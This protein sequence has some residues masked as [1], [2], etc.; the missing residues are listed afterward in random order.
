MRH[1]RYIRY[2]PLRLAVFLLLLLTWFTQSMA[3]SETAVDVAG[4]ADNRINV[5]LRADGP[6]TP[7]GTATMTLEATPLVDAPD[8]SVR[9]QTPPGATLIG[10]AEESFGAVSAGRTVTSQRQVRFDS[11]GVYKMVVSAGFNLFA[12]MRFGA[13]GVLFFTVDPIAPRVSDK[14]PNAVSPMRSIIPAEVTSTAAT[15][16]TPSMARSADGDPCFYVSGTVVRI[17]RPTLPTGYGPDVI[18]PVTNALVEVNEEDIIFD[19]TYAE[20]YTDENGFFSTSFCDDDGVFD[21]ELEIYVTLWSEIYLDGELVAEVEDSSYIDENYEFETSPKASEGGSLTFNLSL[22]RTQSAIFNIADA[23]LDAYIVWRDNGGEA[24]GDSIFEEEGEVHWEPG[25]GDTGSHYISELGEITIADDPSDPDEWDDSVIIHEWGHMADDLYSCDDSPGGDHFVNQLV[26]DP[27][28][29]WGEGYPDYWQSA[30]RAARGRATPS[31]YLDLDGSESQ[32]ISINLENYHVAQPG[33][34]SVRNELAI[35]AALWDLQDTA[36][37]GQDTVAHGQ[38]MIQEVYTNDTFESN[39]FF[40]DDCDFDTFARA[41]VEDGKPADAAT[42]AVFM[43]NTGYTLSPDSSVSRSADNPAA[44]AFAGLLG[45][46]DGAWWNRV[47]YVAD[48]SASMAGAK[49]DAV[50]TVIGEAILDL[51]AEPEGTEFTLTTFNN[52]SLTNQDVFAGQFFPER[53]E[54]A[55]SGMTTSNT[56]DPNCNV[57]AL[58]ALN[59]AITNQYGGYAWLFTD[60]DTIQFPSVENMKKALTDRHIRASVAL[61]GVCPALNL[62]LEADAHSQTQLEGAAERYLGLAADTIP[63]G[64]V[65]YLLTAI[66]SGGH[67]LF[68]DPAQAENAA[69]ILRAQITHSAGAGSWSDYVSDSATYRYDELASWEYQWLDASGLGTDHGTPAGASG[70]SYVNVMLPT[71]FDYYG[72]GIY[73]FARVYENGYMTLGNNYGEARNN[74]T[75]PNA[76][77]PNNALYPYWDDLEWQLICLTNEV[78]CDRNGKIYSLQDGDWFAIEYDNYYAPGHEGVY[79][80]FQTQ[81]NLQTGEIRYLYGDL[82][83]VGAPGATIGLENSTGTHAVQVSYND[84]AGASN[85]MGYKFVPAPPQPTRTYTTTV[86]A[87]MD[88]V[89]FLLTGYDGS[90]EKLQ[91]KYPNG[92]SVSC[93]DTANVLCLDLGLVQYVQANVNGRYGEWTAVV[94]AGPTGSGTFSFFSMAASPISVKSL[95]D[96]NLGVLASPGPVVSLGQAVDGNV[97]TGRFKTP[98]NLPF[99]APFTLYDDGAHGDK[100]A[101]DGIFGADLFTPPGAGSAYLHV[102]GAIGGISFVRSD[103]VPYT[104]QPVSLESLGD[105]VNTGGV[106]TLQFKLTNQDTFE[107]SYFLEVSAPSGWNADAVSGPWTLPPGASTII[108]VQVDMGAV[109]N[110]L[111]SGTTGEVTLTAIEQEEGIISDT[112]TAVV[113]R[114][115]QPLVIE[116]RNPI[117]FLEPGGRTG[118]LEIVVT[119]EQGV[120]VADGTEVQLSATLGTVEP[121]IG[122]THSGVLY[123]KFSS[124]PQTG[125]AVVTAS[126]NGLSETTE[127]EIATAPANAITLEVSDDQ[128]PTGGQA[129]V[130]LVA[131]VTNRRGE[132]LAGQM[133]RIGIEGDGRYGTL[134][135]GQEVVEGLTNSDGQLTAVFRSGNE[136]GDVGVRAQLLV[137][138]GKTTRAVHE[139]RK[140]IHLTGSFTLYLP[141]ALR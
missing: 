14:D 75:L 96:Y 69:D 60:G 131:T 79:M 136:V 115:R 48:N 68:V 41:W 1:L 61:M 94:D 84:K 22:D 91:V 106:T 7:G 77:A 37:D 70:E 31:F 121:A 95:R 87:L 120:A 108:D 51:E 86:D 5:V 2:T 114:R 54:A 56:A 3:A 101:G 73:S 130:T 16:T 116:I 20:L 63:S 28:L 42:A 65:P 44:P 23:I 38:A 124:G 26:D 133:V 85:G 103:P 19:D 9:W 29:A 92:Q 128:L 43:Q 119:D 89:G 49:F 99:G 74:T 81:F 24:G 35:A 80:N 93:N 123:V 21:D 64:I 34:I 11:D 134:S 112:A 4:G 140:V 72:T 57:G 105:G 111:P 32:G 12:E 71:P 39:G 135:D 47:T 76:A 36:N 126:I 83:N 107:H 66:N 40:D 55:V 25:Y 27:E 53:L 104:F 98:T 15:A 67:F 18:V 45:P 90:F 132:P 129:T 141:V 110:N 122:I 82:Q 102:E 58:N 6:V 109:P 78:T 100:A 50:K 118:T 117:R 62:E 33:V 97:L 88:G 127:I 137:A 30:V 46:S 59:Q 13:S 139:D 52:T 125:T 138:D 113:T 8:L 10:A 17:D